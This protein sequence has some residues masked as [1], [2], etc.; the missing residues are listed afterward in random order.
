MNGS[1]EKVL[2][3]NDGSW[4]CGND[5]Q[6]I[7][8]CDSGNGS[9]IEDE[10]VTNVKPS[11]SSSPSNSASPSTSSSPSR[12]AS[13]ESKIIGIAAGVACFLLVVAGLV[14]FAIGRRHKRQKKWM[15]NEQE[16]IGGPEELE[17][18][19]HRAELNDK[20]ARF[21]MEQ[22]RTISELDEQAPRACVE[23]TGE[24]T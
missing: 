16:G 7:A 9:W 6:A 2:Q 23:N 24:V 17:A 21:E 8:C 13:G 12:G 1:D 10:H 5:V 3:C 20:G 11:N 14:G 15:L 4:C 19:E 22:P 18:I